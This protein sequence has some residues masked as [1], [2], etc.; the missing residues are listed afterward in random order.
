MFDSLCSL[1]RLFGCCRQM[2]NSGPTHAPSGSP[3]LL[4][5]AAR[6]PGPCRAPE[7]RVVAVG[8]SGPTMSQ[9]C[10]NTVVALFASPG[11]ARVSL[12]HFSSFSSQHRAAAYFRPSPCSLAPSQGRCA[13]CGPQRL[14]QPLHP[15]AV[16]LTDKNC[17]CTI[18]LLH[19][20][21]AFSLSH[22][23][24]PPPSPSLSPPSFSKGRP[25][26]RQPWT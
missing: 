8:R 22:S 26:H 19:A 2:D 20:W 6:R 21:P 1:S 18:A 24:P 9:H 10:C 11:R 17:T 12:H 14:R 25:P 3:T 7:A 16:H 15:G 23:S 5:G 4:P 13:G